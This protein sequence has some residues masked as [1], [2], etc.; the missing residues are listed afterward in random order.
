MNDVTG[1]PAASG[2][3]SLIEHTLRDIGIPPCPA[4]LSRIV[5]EIRKDEPDFHLL[6]G[7]IS[8]D[9]GLAAGLIKTANSPYFG[10]QQRAR[11]VHEALSILG[12]NVASQAIAGLIMRNV[13]PPT[14]T[15]NRF[16]DGSAR[17]ARLSGWLSQRLD[18][19][20]LAPEDAHTFGL[21]RDC[22]I[23]V[24]FNRYPDYVEILAT[25]NREPQRNF[26]EIESASL[27]TNHAVVGD[28]M[29]RSWWLP[30]QISLA[31]RHHHDL[32]MLHD[33]SGPLT[34]T[35]RRLIATAQFAEHILQR[36]LGLSLTHEWDK[37]GGT[38]VALLQ[39]DEDDLEFLYQD[40]A[41]VAAAES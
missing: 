7:I 10:R 14:P 3:D 36:Q 38:C 15:M 9:V 34:L 33:D 31:I 37:L 20:G 8:A 23:P 12:L 41:P 26:T 2:I 18:I 27:P 11:T 21:F 5:T 13:F 40:A 39:V 4:I 35:S 29:A 30:E 17:I 28:S 16:W 25:A 24:L 1:E 32:D 22:G 19:R 6:T